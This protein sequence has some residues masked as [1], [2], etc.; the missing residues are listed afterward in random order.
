M[1]LSLIPPLHP[2]S[3]V[4]EPLACGN[5][6]TKHVAGIA[7]PEYIKKEGLGPPFPQIQAAA[8]A[9]E[10]P[11]PNEAFEFAD[12]PLPRKAR[13]FYLPIRDL[14]SRI[15][16]EFECSSVVPIVRWGIS[17]GLFA[18]GGKINLLRDS[19]DPY[20][21]MDRATIFPEQLEGKCAAYPDW[22][23][24]RVFRLRGFR[25]TMRLKNPVFIPSETDWGG[26]GLEKVELRVEVQPDASVTSPV[27]A[28]PQYAYWNFLPR[29]NACESTL[30]NPWYAG[31]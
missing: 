22:G 11:G 7:T 28:A 12:K 2:K 23:A 21:R 27:A 13:G 26:K 14:S 29:P 9:G 6:I 30:L 18:I 16:Y 25:L 31:N 3:D 19:T 5:V 15:A 1:F 4:A 20:S 24:E 17:C 10:L 8:K